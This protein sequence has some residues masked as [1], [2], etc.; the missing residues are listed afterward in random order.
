MSNPSTPHPIEP[1]V[2]KDFVQ[3]ALKR[4]RDISLKNKIFFSILAVILI[5]SAII[6]FLARWI[7]VSTLI[8]ELE[9]RGIAIARTI[10]DLAGRDGIELSDVAEA[11]Q[12]RPKVE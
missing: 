7:L 12:Y 5:I 8:S 10:A 9:L 6:A 4:F 2:R 11:L 3:G 1:V